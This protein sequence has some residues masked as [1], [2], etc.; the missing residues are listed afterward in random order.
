MVPGSFLGTQ[1]NEGTDLSL[2]GRS[3]EEKVE[4]EPPQVPEMPFDLCNV[5]KSKAWMCILDLPLTVIPGSS[6]YFASLSL[7]SVIWNINQF[8]EAIVRIK[9]NNLFEVF[10]LA[11]GTSSLV[12]ICC[13][14]IVNHWPIT[15]FTSQ[16]VA[17]ISICGLVSL[18][19]SG[20]WNTF[21]AIAFCQTTVWILSLAMLLS[22]SSE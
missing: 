4:K 6:L 9:W 7:P 10:S 19:R 3:G 2:G 14:I 1:K 20:A 15:H 11:P 17:D 12:K 5:T 22:L 21:T 8:H 18:P 16:I 13:I